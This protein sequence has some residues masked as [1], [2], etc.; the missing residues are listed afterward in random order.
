MRVTG[1]S[2]VHNIRYGIRICIALYE[3]DIEE[4]IE[5][6]K[7]PFKVAY[8]TETG[9]YL[10]H[11]QVYAFHG[12]EENAEKN[13]RGQRFYTIMTCESFWSSQ[14][15]KAMKKLILDKTI[16]DWW[17]YWP[18]NGESLARDYIIPKQLYPEFEYHFEDAVKQIYKRIQA[19]EKIERLLPL[20]AELQLPVEDIASDEWETYVANR[21]NILGPVSWIPENKDDLL[22]YVREA[23]SVPIASKHLDGYED[24]IFFHEVKLIPLEIASKDE[25][26]V[27]AWTTYLD[28]NPQGVPVA[29]YLIAGKRIYKYYDTKVENK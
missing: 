19:Q 14:Q 1:L 11:L 13:F 17:M 4:V 12:E 16:I 6:T 24:D 5:A 10:H 26:I 8:H 3:K 23:Y 29:E 9:E 27:A 18:R 28:D 15:H 25:E 2:S 7:L 21:L 20:L 22:R